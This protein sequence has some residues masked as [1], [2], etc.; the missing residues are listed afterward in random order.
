MDSR[1]HILGRERT[2]GGGNLPQSMALVVSAATNRLAGADYTYD[3][4]GN[5]VEMPAPNS[6]NSMFMAYLD[7]G[8]IG[9][10][11]DAAG[12]VWKYYYDADGKR[13]IKSKTVNGVSSITDN[14][15]Y[16]FYE[17]EDLICQQD[18]GDLGPPP[19]GRAGGAPGY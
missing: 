12:V 2:G 18:V 3:V 6:P 13:R 10:L 11:T 14:C 5:L 19:P 7:Q 4:L 1:G 16:L 17:G 9:T 8:H 15:S